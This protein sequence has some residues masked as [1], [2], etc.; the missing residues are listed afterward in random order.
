M[1]RVKEQSR[2]YDVMIYAYTDSIF[3]YI[4]VMVAKLGNIFRI[5]GMS[6]VLAAT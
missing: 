2:M 5:D 3:K 4:H 6:K 1:G